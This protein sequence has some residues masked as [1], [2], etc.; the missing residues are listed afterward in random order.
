M[1]GG[2]PSKSKLVVFDNQGGSHSGIPETRITT[3]AIGG[4]VNFSSNM[5]G[6]YRLLM[7]WKTWGS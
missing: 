2:G 4:M 7:P 3:P 1:K 5:T 6:S